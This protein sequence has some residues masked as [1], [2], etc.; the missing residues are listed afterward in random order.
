MEQN[1]DTEVTGSTKKRLTVKSTQKTSH[2]AKKVYAPFEIMRQMKNP[3]NYDVVIITL[4]R[5]EDDDAV[6]ARAAR[7][8]VH[9]LPGE[10]LRKAK[11]FT[12]NRSYEGDYN[13]DI[14][15]VDTSDFK[16]TEW[17]PPMMSTAFDMIR[18]SL[19]NIT[20]KSND[21]LAIRN[22]EGFP[23]NDAFCVTV[24]NNEEPVFFALRTRTQLVF[25]YDT[26][27]TCKKKNIS[28][29]STVVLE[30]QK[31]F[32]AF[33]SEVTK[34]ETAYSTF[35]LRNALGLLN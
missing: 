31:L 11:T 34:I 21:F 29:D 5:Y 16:V 6:Y 2:I 15:S 13:D 35:A 32:L 33:L 25:L 27:H 7:S 19:E 17:Y 4:E 8:L 10:N 20:K 26:F 18:K 12:L 24:S 30:C 28:A 22:I 3:S 23:I 9:D 1:Q 14:L